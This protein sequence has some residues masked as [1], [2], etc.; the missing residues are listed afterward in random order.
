MVYLYVQKEQDL[1]IVARGINVAHP[2]AM[3]H[4]TY[5][6]HQNFCGQT[7]YSSLD[8]DRCLELIPREP[9]R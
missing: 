9:G 2:L 1:R 4:S 7:I 8:C 5:I 6:G 3:H